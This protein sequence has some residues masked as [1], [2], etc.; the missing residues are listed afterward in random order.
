MGVGWGDIVIESSALGK[1]KEP[2]TIDIYELNN[3]E[4]PMKIIGYGKAVLLQ[5]L[6]E[7]LPWGSDDTL[8]VM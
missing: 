2:L 3:Q 8:G 4:I 7:F 5:F 6:L 1:H